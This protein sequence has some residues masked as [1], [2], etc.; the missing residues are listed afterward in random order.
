MDEAVL[1]PERNARP[2]YTLSHAQ[3]RRPI[4]DESI[5]RWRNYPWAFDGRWD[6]GPAPPS[7][8]SSAPTH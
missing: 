4:N 2:A 8:T 7:A 3:V 5:G 6:D 1:S